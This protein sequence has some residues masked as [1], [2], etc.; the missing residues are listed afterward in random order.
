[1]KRPR[2]LI[3]PLLVVAL[4]AAACGSS[5]SPAARVGDVQITDA[6]VTA[7]AKGLAFLSDL[8]QAPCGGEVE[9]G[10][11]ADAPCNR[12]ALSRLILGE[13][14]AAHP[15]VAVPASEVQAL[16]ENLDSQIGAAQVD[17]YLEARGL[18]RAG[19]EQLV[20]G[21]LEEV[22][23]RRAVAEAELG[24][25]GLEQLY[26]EHVLEF[27]SLEAAHIL[28][29]TEA[30]ANDV[31]DRVTAAGA[32]EDTFATVARQESTDTSTKDDG[33]LL[34][35]TP[36]SQLAPAFTAGAIA[37]EPGEISPPVQTEFGWHV[38]RLVSTEV[39]SLADAKDDLIETSAG[40]VIQG[41]LRD[42]ARRR[43]V[44]VNPRFGRFDLESLLVVRVTSTDASATES[45]SPA[46]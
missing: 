14:L 29:E 27:T 15:V 2:L 23:Q 38:I 39:R 7:E 22:P 20:R 8:N 36:A 24:A 43:G 12:F 11:S 9:A 19:L 28:V 31:Y 5:A 33:G 17:T 32:D 13:L 35:E 34:P 1:M 37:L 21:F 46:P 25:D 4:S 26:Q 44:D 10:E 3:V 6:Q 16:I 40:D 30:E 18:D 41:W 42:E 45:V